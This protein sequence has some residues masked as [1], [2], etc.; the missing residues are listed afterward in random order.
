MGMGV[1]CA[2]RVRDWGISGGW[3]ALLAGASILALHTSKDDVCAD[4]TD[5]GVIG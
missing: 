4:V 1:G 5:D 3:H 2:D